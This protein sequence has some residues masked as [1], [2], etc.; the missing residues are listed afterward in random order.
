MLN[1]PK[2]RFSGGVDYCEWSVS[3]TTGMSL[4]K[5]FNSH[6]MVPAGP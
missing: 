1:G 3:L 6:Y 5:K 4:G 2:F